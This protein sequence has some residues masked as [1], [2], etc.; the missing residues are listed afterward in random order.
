MGT[1]SD[2]SETVRTYFSQGPGSTTNSVWCL[3]CLSIERSCCLGRDRIVQYVLYWYG[4]F[5]QYYTVNWSP[6]TAS[7]ACSVLLAV[8]IP[9]LLALDLE[10][11]GRKREKEGQYI[12]FLAH[13]AHVH[14]VTLCSAPARYSVLCSIVCNSCLV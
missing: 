6:I 5:V 10:V 2:V 11:R 13:T 9:L 12:S 1:S 3:V 8:G 4:K 7:I 14:G